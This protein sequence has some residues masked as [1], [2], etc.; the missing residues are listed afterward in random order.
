MITGLIF[1]AVY[2]VGQGLIRWWKY[3]AMDFTEVLKWIVSWSIG[4]AIICAAVLVPIGM[5]LDWQ[6]KPPKKLQKTDRNPGE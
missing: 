6:N 4:S 1:G 3:P 2:G 5:F